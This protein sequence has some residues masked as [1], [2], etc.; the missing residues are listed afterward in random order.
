MITRIEATRY[1]CLEKLD[2]DLGQYAVLVGANGAGKTTFLDIPGLLADCLQQRNIGQAFTQDR[3]YGQP[4]RTSA[5]KE[6]VFATRGN[7]FIFSLEARLPGAIVSQ[8]LPSQT[9]TVQ[10]DESK[11]LQ[12]IRYEVRFSIFNERELQVSNE[13]CFLFSDSSIPDRKGPRLHGEIDKDAARKRWRF[14][15]DRELGGGVN[16]RPDMQRTGKF[17]DTHAD[18]TML[19]L[20]RVQFESAEDYPASR[21]LFD[22]LVAGAIF[23]EPN[24][25][26]LQVASPPAMGDHLLPDA[27]NLPH[28]AKALHDNKATRARFDDWVAHVQTALPQV[29][30]IN[31]GIQE[32]DKA[33]FFVITYQGGHQVSSYGLSEGTLRILAL[34][35]IPYLVSAPAL[36]ITEEPENGIHPRAIESVLQSL[37]SAYDSQVLISSHSPVA[38]AHTE[39]DHLLCARVAPTGSADIISGS[40]HPRL[41]EWRGA[42]DLGALFATGVLG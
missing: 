42:I 14:I 33:A 11:W 34:T 12:Y 7:D 25:D 9:S 37:G 41:K 23:Y 36:I 39:L 35:L 24:I 21:W 30:D 26:K 18:A 6:L 13:Y 3:G 27:S 40:H 38:L 28:L 20:P 5:L 31:I 1:R 29:T 22:L 2:V 15:I 17:K 32:H 4:P 16:L 19:S 8:L 10:N